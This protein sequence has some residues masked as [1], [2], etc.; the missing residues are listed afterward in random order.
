MDCNDG[1]KSMAIRNLRAFGI[2]RF[3]GIE[4][5]RPSGEAVV[6]K[7]A[8]MLVHVLSLKDPCAQAGARRRHLRSRQRRWEWT[9]VH[10]VGQR[11]GGHARCVE[12]S[13]LRKA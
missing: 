9:A 8:L 12:S 13:M 10:F 1:E 5:F 7:S 4:K 6:L 3:V 11:H 2:G